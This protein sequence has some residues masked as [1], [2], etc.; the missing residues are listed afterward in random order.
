MG[1]FWSPLDSYSQNLTKNHV[2]DITHN[3]SHFT[4]NIQNNND[5]HSG[6]LQQFYKTDPE[7]VCQMFVDENHHVDNSNAYDNPAFHG[8]KKAF[9]KSWVS[10][11]ILK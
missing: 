6:A 3:A 1:Y 5:Q 10:Y 7:E 2:W 4:H 8:E 11:Q 9:W